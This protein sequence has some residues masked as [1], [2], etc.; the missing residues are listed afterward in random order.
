MR[1][2]LTKQAEYAIRILVWLSSSEKADRAEGVPTARHKAAEI[3]AATDVPP[4]FATRI[5]A[6]LQRRGL[7]LARAGQQGGYVLE[8]SAHSI[9]LLDVVEAVE[10]PLI[11]R[12]CV[13]RDGLCGENG[14]CLLHDAWSASREAL[15]SIL[16]GTPLG[17]AAASH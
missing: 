6:L 7:L 8:R 13:M 1:L 10:G 17:I 3:T 11:T 14:H 9:S 5:L 2:A 15:R 12:E 16:A 4:V